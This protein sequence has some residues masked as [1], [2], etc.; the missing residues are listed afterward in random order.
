LAP[1]HSPAVLTQHN[2]N[3]RTGANLDE[4][5]LTPATVSKAT[6]GLLFTRKVQGM[7]Y[8]QPL[9]VPGIQMPGKGKR[10]VVYVATEHNDVYAFD[11]N[12]PDA[13]EPLWH[14]NLGESVPSDD[15]TVDDTTIYRNII[16][17]LGISSTPVID[18]GRQTIYLSGMAKLNGERI[19]RVY[20]LDIKDGSARPN[21]P[22]TLNITGK[23]TG[24]GSVNGAITISPHHIL[25]RPGLAIANDVLWIAGGG[26]GDFT[27]PF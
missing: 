14:V 26:H 16:P 6:F 3:A 7:I 25:Q 12:D 9:F 17:E 8:A 2:D 1:A 21:S 5:V 22:V 13:G 19:N 24:A 18:L 15:L 4:T 23:G 20:A 10:D 11:A 27:T